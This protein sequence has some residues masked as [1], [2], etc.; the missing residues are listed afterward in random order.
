[1]YYTCSIPGI[2]FVELAFFA[3][4]EN[5]KLEPP[6]VHDEDSAFPLH[7]WNALPL[8]FP[9]ANNNRD[10]STPAFNSVAVTDEVSIAFMK[11]IADFYYSCVSPISIFFNNDE[12]NPACNNEQKDSSADP[13]ASPDRPE[14]ENGTESPKE[15]NVSSVDPE[16]DSDTS[17]EGDNTKPSGN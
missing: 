5:D 6:R 12:S 2:S 8:A 16:V 13:E 1:M 14:S 9:A 10:T 3:I 11:Y 15:K 4:E 17:N 7:N